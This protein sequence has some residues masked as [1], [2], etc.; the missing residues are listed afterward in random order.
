V[1]GRRYAAGPALRLGG[2]AGDRCVDVALRGERAA[3]DQLDP[4]AGE[5]V[6]DRPVKPEP[7]PRD[8]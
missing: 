3:F 8:L 6:V 5:R 7:Q 1:I 2:A 4:G